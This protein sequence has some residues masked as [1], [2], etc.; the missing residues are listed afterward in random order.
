MAVQTQINKEWAVRLLLIFVMAAAFGGWFAYDGAV[1]WPRE[2]RKAEIAYSDLA[3][4]RTYDDWKDRLRN[5]GYTP[6][7]TPPEYRQP[8]DIKTQFIYASICGVAA[9]AVLFVLLRNT[10]R[11]LRSDDK[12]V[13]RGSQ[14]VPFSSIT[15]ID[16][17]RWD[18]KGIAVL[19]YKKSDGSN[20]RLKLDDWVYR[21]AGKILAEVE[22]H[23]NLAGAKE[24]SA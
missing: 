6:G 3:S 1:A 20:A 15:S 9:I 24:Q 16:K 17:I 21:G 7:T 10:Q 12:G 18:N 22:E 23:T 4:R 8:L 13:Y 14:F 19:Y 11:K 5:E 2:N